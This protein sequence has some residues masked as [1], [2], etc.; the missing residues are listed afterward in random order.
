MNIQIRLCTEDLATTDCSGHTGISFSN[1][2]EAEVMNEGNGLFTVTVD[3]HW[4]FDRQ[5]IKE[6]RAY[7]KKILKDTKA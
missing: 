5:A 6:L 2:A 7:L 1:M 3:S 4:T